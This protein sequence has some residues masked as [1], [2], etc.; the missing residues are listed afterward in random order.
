MFRSFSLA[1]LSVTRHAAMMIM[2]WATSDPNSIVLLATRGIIVSSPGEPSP[3][4]GAL[5]AFSHSKNLPSPPLL[6]FVFALDL[7]VKCVREC[8]AGTVSSPPLASF[9]SDSERFSTCYKAPMSFWS[10]YARSRFAAIG[11]CAWLGRLSFAVLVAWS[12]VVAPH[13]RPTSRDSGGHQR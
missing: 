8:G 6:F 1:T 2:G 3:A 7:E 9:T 4:I 12:P 5:S 13:P 10:C 11:R